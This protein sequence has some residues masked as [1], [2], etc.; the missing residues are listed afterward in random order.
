MWH[1]QL[2]TFCMNLTL[3]ST[4]AK[5][6]PTTV[7]L[8]I[9]ENEIWETLFLVTLYFGLSFRAIFHLVMILCQNFSQNLTWRKIVF[10]C[11]LMFTWG[12][13]ILDC[14]YLNLFLLSDQ[15]DALNWRR[16]HIMVH[17]KIGATVKSIA[18]CGRYIRQLNNWKSCYSQKKFS[19]TRHRLVS[20]I[21]V[22][23]PIV[24]PESNF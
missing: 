16:P 5:T 10:E 9:V 6:H 3:I 4:S 15:S 7:S 8:E 13:I 14:F 12:I 2:S 17:Y 23:S 24:D 11:I 19:F 1:F 22:H 18:F 20:H 21:I